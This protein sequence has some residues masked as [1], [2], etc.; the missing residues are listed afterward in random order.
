[1]VCWE[2]GGKRLFF[3]LL[4]VAAAFAWRSAE[5]N[6]RASTRHRVEAEVI[7]I[8]AASFLCEQLCSLTG[9]WGGALNRR[10][11]RCG[12]SMRARIEQPKM[13]GY[14]QRKLMELVV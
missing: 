8:L 10:T 12:I 2:S 11:G 6:R 3:C 14:L 4:T 5:A 9:R 13:P 7:A 1:M